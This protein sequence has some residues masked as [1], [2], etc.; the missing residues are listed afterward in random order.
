[1]TGI[2]I[3]KKKFGHRHSQRKDHVRTQ[4]E[5]GHLSHEERSQEKPSGQQL[6]LELLTFRNMTIKSYCLRH[7]VCGTLLW[8]P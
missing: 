6:N 3:K 2:I 5:D 4:E 7:P 8:D 1:M